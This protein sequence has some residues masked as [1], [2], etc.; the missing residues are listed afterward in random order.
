MKGDDDGPMA[1]EDEPVPDR[2]LYDSITNFME[3]RLAVDNLL[4]QKPE[5]M[6][7]EGRG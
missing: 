6:E 7:I 5:L 3:N 1:E 2:R 4:L